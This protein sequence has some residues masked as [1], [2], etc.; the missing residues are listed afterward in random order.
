MHY[1]MYCN[2]NYENIR[3]SQYKEYYKHCYF[4]WASIYNEIN[5]YTYVNIKKNKDYDIFF[6]KI[7]PRQSFCVTVVQI[8]S[9]F[10]DQTYD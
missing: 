3:V 7:L 4:K 2:F 10:V 8:I 6:L 1:L 5:V 9:P